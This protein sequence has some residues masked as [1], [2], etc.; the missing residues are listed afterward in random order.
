MK[1]VK[2][3]IE[4]DMPLLSDEITLK[5]LRA[6][7]REFVTAQCCDVE[8]IFACNIDQLGTVQRLPGYVMRGEWSD[9]AKMFYQADIVGAVERFRFTLD[10]P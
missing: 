3:V 9:G 5:G 10:K 8:I 6:I 7:H 2:V 4:M 1:K